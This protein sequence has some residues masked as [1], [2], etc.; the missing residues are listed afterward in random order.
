[1]KVIMVLTLTLFLSLFSYGNMQSYLDL[2]EK[3]SKTVVL[4]S[5]S[6]PSKGD[7]EDEEKYFSFVY[8]RQCDFS[9]EVHSEEKNYFQNHTFPLTRP[10][11]SLFV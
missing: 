7:V 8:A 4:D 6:K 11:S 2:V 1:M 3:S 9:N 5:D 10:P